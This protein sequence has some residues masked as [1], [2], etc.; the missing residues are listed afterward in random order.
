MMYPFPKQDSTKRVLHANK[1][2]CYSVFIFHVVQFANMQ[3]RIQWLSVIAVMTGSNRSAKKYLIK[4]FQTTNFKQPISFV[5]DVT[6]DLASYNARLSLIFTS[7]MK[8]E[9]LSLFGKNIL[10]NFTRFYFYF[11]LLVFKSIYLMKTG[12]LNGFLERN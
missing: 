2:S 1:F 7:E 3:E 10:Q 5:K 8:C 6:K 11:R 9:L 4:C 12:I